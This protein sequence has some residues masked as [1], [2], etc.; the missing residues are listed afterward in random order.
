[1]PAS[2]DTPQLLFK[3]FWI[4]RVIQLKLCKRAA[5]TARGDGGRGW[6]AGPTLKVRY[7]TIRYGTKVFGDAI[8]F[9]VIRTT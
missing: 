5:R 8:L 6:L 9:F 1:M 2:L 7:G 3:A 4:A